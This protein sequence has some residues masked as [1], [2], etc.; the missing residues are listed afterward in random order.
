MCVCIAYVVMMFA[1]VL[2][3]GQLMGVMRNRTHAPD[4]QTNRK[5]VALAYI[6][7]GNNSCSILN[8]F[9][10]FYKILEERRV[11]NQNNN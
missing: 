9:L 10:K 3:V 2:G 6:E 1:S 4:L 7:T 5:K 11:H 8:I